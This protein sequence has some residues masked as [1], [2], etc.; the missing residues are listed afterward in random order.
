MI[1]ARVFCDLAILWCVWFREREILLE[2]WL[3]SLTSNLTS[4]LEALPDA[5]RRP[6]IMFGRSRWRKASLS[7]EAGCSVAMSKSRRKANFEIHGP[8]GWTDSAVTVGAGIKGRELLRLANQ[9]SPKV[10][11]VT[12]ECPTVGFAGGYIQGGGHGPLASYYGMAADQALSYEVITA[13][14]EYLTANADTNPDLYWGLRGGGPS[15]FAFLLSVTVKTFPE[16]PSAG[17]VLSLNTNNNQDLFWRGFAAFP[18]P[19]TSLGGER[20]VRVLRALRRQ[21]QHPP[22]RRCEHDQVEDYRGRAAAVRPAP[23]LGHLNESAGVR[24]LVGGYS[25]RRISMRTGTPSSTR[26]GVQALG[27]WVTSSALAVQHPAWRDAASFSISS[28]NLAAQAMRAQKQE[29]QTQLTNSVDAPLR[30]ASPNGAAYVNEGN[31]EEPDWQKAYWGSNY[32]RL[33]ELR[34]KWDPNGVFYARTTPGTEAWEVVDYR[35]RLCRLASAGGTTTTTTTSTGST[36][37]TSTVT[38]PTTTTS[39]PAG[40]LQTSV[41]GRGGQVRLNH[42]R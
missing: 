38:T 12:G 8:G 15:T 40:P 25:R 18:Q 31:L 14:G 42:Q 4:I 24:S 27:S 28:V 11:I 29:A 19:L 20:H 9:Q 36:G 22:V 35:R 16:T 32:P 39:T 1:K 17:L 34:K 7:A 6:L 37:T 5:L 33:L 13:S 26:C 3:M 10:A 30:A 21:P 41:V 23:D 2:E